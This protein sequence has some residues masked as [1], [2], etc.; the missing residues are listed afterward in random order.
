MKARYRLATGMTEVRRTPKF[1][2]HK[3]AWESMRKKMLGRYATLYRETLIEVPIVNRTQYIKAYN[4]KYTMQKIGKNN[5]ESV[6]IPVLQ[7]NTKHSYR[8]VN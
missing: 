8:G 5:I 7:G 2:N 3:Q 6:W 4:K 1:S